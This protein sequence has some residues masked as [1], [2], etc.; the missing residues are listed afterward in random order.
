[1]HAVGLDVP[2]VWI[3]YFSLTGN[4]DEVEID[5]YLHGLTD[6]LPLDRNLVSHAVNELIAE[7]PPPAAPYTDDHMDRHTDSRTDDA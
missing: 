1:M 5:A 7:T 4:A 3:R 6:L 2:S